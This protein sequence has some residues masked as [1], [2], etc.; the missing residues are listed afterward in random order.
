MPPFNRENVVTCLQP[1]LKWDL[2]DVYDCF[3][4]LQR[5]HEGADPSLVG[6]M[7]LMLVR[8]SAEVPRLMAEATAKVLAQRL[9]S[10][11]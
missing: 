4:V 9:K 2:S 8:E 11:A 7:L 1:Y 5:A 6:N 10:L 3:D